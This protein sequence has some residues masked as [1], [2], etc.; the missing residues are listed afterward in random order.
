MADTA[1]LRKLEKQN[2]IGM[3]VIMK[4]VN[5]GLH[6]TT[7]KNLFATVNGTQLEAS[8]VLLKNGASAS[9]QDKVLFNKYDTLSHRRS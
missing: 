7:V 3:P 5:N 8:K 2:R 9:F 1:N 4:Q 6:I